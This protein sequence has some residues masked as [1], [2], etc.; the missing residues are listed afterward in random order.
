MTDSRD[1]ILSS[2]RAA[3]GSALLPGSAPDRPAHNVPRASGGVDQF[4]EEASQLS[5]QVIRVRTAQEAAGAVAALFKE[6]GWG[7][8][9]AW[10]WEAI[11]CEGL[12][13]ALAGAD[14]EAVQTGDPPE[15]ASI[16]VGITGAEA[17]LADTGSIVLRN[18]AGRS[19]LASLL[20]PVHVALLDAS[21]IFPDMLT[22]LDGLAG[23]GGA[24]GYTRQTSNLVFISG[25]SRTADIEQTLTLGVHGPRE[26]IIVVWG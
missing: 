7:R 18:G 26:L 4:V 24:A 23:E 21:R 6:R 25:P 8:A 22:F 2:I 19:P 11:G 13:D 14:V 1:H 17:G 3:L 16:P 5:A 9:L 20:P 10:A 15:L 12:A